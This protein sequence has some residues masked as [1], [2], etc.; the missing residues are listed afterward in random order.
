MTKK[1]KIIKVKSLDEFAEHIN[2][3]RSKV[4]EAIK[5]DPDAKLLEEYK[6][7][8]KDVLLEYINKFLI[9]Y[10][11]VAVAHKFEEKAKQEIWMEAINIKLF[12][13]WLEDEKKLKL[14]KQ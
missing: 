11:D 2:L 7:I 1:I 9:E 13:Q 12:C 14:V 5:T 6:G 4:K 10:Y 8:F 3:D